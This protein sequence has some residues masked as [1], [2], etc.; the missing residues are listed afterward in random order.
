[1]KALL[2]KIRQILRDRRTRQFLTRFVSATA[3]IVVFV[4][5]Y[6]LVLPAITMES[7]A[8]CG[9]EAHQHDDSC[10][11][12]ELICGQEESEGHHHTDSCYEKVLIC[13]KEVHIHSEECYKSDEM[14]IQS[15]AV[16]STGSTSVSVASESLSDEE[17]YSEDTQGE[18]SNSGAWAEP[19]R[20]DSDDETEYLQKDNEYISEDDLGLEA[21]TGDSFTS[22]SEN[23]KAEGNSPEDVIADESNTEEVTADENSPEDVVADENSTEEVTAD[24]NSP[25]DVIADENS[26]EEVTADEDSTEDEEVDVNGGEDYLDDTSAQGD[27]NADDGSGTVDADTNDYDAVDTDTVDSEDTENSALGA[28]SDVLPDSMETEELSDGYVPELDMLNVDAILTKK[29]GFYYYHAEEGDEMPESSALI[30]PEDWKE[31]KE[32]GLA[33]AS[34]AGSALYSSL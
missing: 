21:D 4:T 10:Y 7:Q 26:T 11:T 13:G 25:E 2:I 19:D 31:Y 24:E 14:E 1:M 29:T 15:S 27:M 18:G 33:A 20:N 12:E 34:V 6:A 5:T 3:A 16:A 9:I 32:K 28:T 30:S 23:I 8:A 17:Y 22:D